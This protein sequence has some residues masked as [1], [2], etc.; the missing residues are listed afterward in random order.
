MTSRVL[1]VALIAAAA[2]SVAVV[3]YFALGIGGSVMTDEE[4]VQNQQLAGQIPVG[5]LAPVTGAL[6]GIGEEYLA[7]TSIAAADVNEYLQAQGEPWAIK[8]ILEDTESRPDITLE[9]TMDLHAQGARVIVGPVASASVHAIKNYVDANGMLA[10]ACCS[11]ASAVAI[12]GDNIY[13][14]TTVD[15]HYIGIHAEAARSHGMDNL[16]H[17]YRGDVWGDGINEALKAGFSEHGGTVSNWIRYNPGTAD[18][19]EV[20]RHLSE[21]VGEVTETTDPGRV[22]IVVSSYAEYLDIMREATS[23]DILDDVTWFGIAT[24]IGDP[25]IADDPVIRAFVDKVGLYSITLSVPDSQYYRQVEAVI[26]E[27]LGYEPNPFI[28]AAYD[29]VWIMALTMLDAQ[30][31]NAD[32]LKASIADVAEEYQGVTGDI[33][34]NDAGD[35]ADSDYDVWRVSD[36]QWHVAGKYTQLDGY[37]VLDGSG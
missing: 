26:T 27:R 31:T 28:Y 9:K 10:L 14:L 18:Y 30:T 33:R 21:I 24:P 1:P 16:I 7:I 19:A 4:P 22:G 37:T 20:A 3:A 6:S 23:Y 13:R 35:L 17:V 2:I 32:G 36:G 25:Q 11:S 15:I 5:L 34:F 12:P 8:L 29:S